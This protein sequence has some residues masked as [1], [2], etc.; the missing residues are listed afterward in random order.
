MSIYS[1]ISKKIGLNPINICIPEKSLALSLLHG[2]QDGYV[3]CFEEIFKSYR[4]CPSPTNAEDEE[5]MKIICEA[6]KIGC[7]NPNW[8]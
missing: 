8:R 5:V 7:N 4:F 1:D 6:Y 3:E 2:V